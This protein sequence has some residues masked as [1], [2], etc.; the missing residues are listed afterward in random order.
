MQLFRGLIMKSISPPIKN[1]IVYCSP[2]AQAYKFNIS[3]YLRSFA[4]SFFNG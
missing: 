3:V 4:D 2:Q 1:K